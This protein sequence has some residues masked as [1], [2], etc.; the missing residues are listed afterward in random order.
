MVVACVQEDTS[1]RN[2]QFRVPHENAEQDYEEH[3]KADGEQREAGCLKNAA[4]VH[5][6]AFSYDWWWSSDAGIQ[7]ECELT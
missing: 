6:L 3:L 5:D 1:L 7:A 2:S 4:D